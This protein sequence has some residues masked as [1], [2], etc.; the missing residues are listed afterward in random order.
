[1]KLI[2]KRLKFRTFRFWS[3]WVDVLGFT[4]ASEGFLLQVRVNRFNGKTFRCI[5]LRAWYNIHAQY[6]DGRYLFD[7]LEK[8][9][10]D[11]KNKDDEKLLK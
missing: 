2:N 3:D 10:I 1:M 9:D 4:W 6:S 5:P 11:N 7:L 8:F